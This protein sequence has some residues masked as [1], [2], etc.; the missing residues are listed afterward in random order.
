M[1]AKQDEVLKL[2]DQLT[3]ITRDH[4][5]VSKEA[6]EAQGL[7]EAEVSGAMVGGWG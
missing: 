2:E 5:K 6:R 3:N 7:W 4:E 1:S